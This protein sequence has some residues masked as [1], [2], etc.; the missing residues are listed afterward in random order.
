MGG[1]GSL[2]VNSEAVGRREGAREARRGVLSPVPLGTV[3]K[4]LEDERTTR[5][6][7]FYALLLGVLMKDGTNMVLIL[8]SGTSVPQKVKQCYQ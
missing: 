1:A 6:S 5:K 7:A 4:R 8:K 3:A 2:T